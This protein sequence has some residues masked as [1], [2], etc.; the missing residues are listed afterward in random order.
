MQVSYTGDAFT[1]LTSIVN[2]VESVNTLGAGV[3]WLDKFELFVST[4]F[5]NPSLINLCNN[6]T[7]NQ[8]NLRCINYKDWV[9][10]FSIDDETI[11]IEAILHTSRIKD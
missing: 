3:R 6:S 7:F 9:I 2:Y 10:A 11:L 4:A 1:T 5:T 8:L